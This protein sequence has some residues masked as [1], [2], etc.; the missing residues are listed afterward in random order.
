MPYIT[1]PLVLKAS[2]LRLQIDHLGH[3]LGAEALVR[4]R[5]PE[6]GLIGPNEF[7]SFAE[8]SD[9][10]LAIGDWVLLTAC[11]QLSLWQQQTP[12]SKLTLSVN[13]SASQVRQPNFVAN[14]VEVLKQTG[15][16]PNTLKLE[17][18]ESMLI[19]DINDVIEKN[20][21]TCG[22]RNTVCLR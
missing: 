7:I 13:I 10:I 22:H 17:I 5:H 3:A 6:R 20:R 9:L 4:W 8:Q 2:A 11:N 21:A 18:T 15:A 19:T 14:V 1:S 16:N 12:T